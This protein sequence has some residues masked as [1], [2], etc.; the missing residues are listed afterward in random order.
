MNGF[1]RK[2]CLGN[3]Q[4]SYAVI[5]LNVHVKKHA[6]KLLLQQIDDNAYML[7]LPHYS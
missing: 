2:S 7:P 4:T 3:A 6:A 1:L 5:W